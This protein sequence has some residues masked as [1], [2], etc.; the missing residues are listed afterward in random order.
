MASNNPVEK[1]ECKY[2]KYDCDTKKIYKVCGLNK[3]W[4]NMKKGGF[5]ECGCKFFSKKMLMCEDCF[6]RPACM[7][8]GHSYVYTDFAGVFW[9]ECYCI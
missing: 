2:C 4:E 6:T 3:C 5:T 8:C 7:V 1:T 9:R